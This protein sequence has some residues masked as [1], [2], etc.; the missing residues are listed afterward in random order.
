MLRRFVPLGSAVM[1][2]VLSLGLLTGMTVKPL[3]LSEMVQYADRVFYG[4]CISAEVKMDPTSGISVREYRFLVDQGLKGVQEQE[5][6][7]VRQLSSMA[8]G[9]PSVAGI[10]TYKK[11]Q[12]L[13]LFLH[14][15]SRLGLTS[16]V[17]MS[18]GTFRPE[19]LKSGEL[20]FRNAVD[21]RNLAQ[22]LDPTGVA[23]QALTKEE[24]ETLQSGGP[25]SLGMFKDVVSKLDQLHER[26]GGVI[27]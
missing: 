7:L 19:R 2:S 23:A 9:G 17:G 1:V 21:N 11:G 24:F 27:K 4:R 13:L 26:E 15:D 8:N 22:D 20:A 18:Q 6:V 14:G 12:K 10:P 16:P 3:N 25:V 5:V